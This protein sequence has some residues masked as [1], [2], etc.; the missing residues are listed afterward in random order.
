MHANR[1]NASSQ[2]F[3]KGEPV[4]LIHGTTTVIVAALLFGLASLSGIEA[5]T[6]V[7]I[8]GTGHVIPSIDGPT[9]YVTYCAV[10]HGGNGDGHG[11]MEAIL[12]VHVPNLTQIAKR[13]GGVFP[14]K[15][16]QRIIAGEKE[17]GLGHGTRQMPIW[18]P[19]FSQVTTD[20]DFGRVRIYNLAKYL[21]S[22]QKQ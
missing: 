6:R 20:Q 19:I 11:P 17:S 22:I 9:L 3:S 13:N 2:A 15:R 14:I 1:P 4:K 18:G 21:E 5:Q 12:S 7:P 10:C 16:V 8:P